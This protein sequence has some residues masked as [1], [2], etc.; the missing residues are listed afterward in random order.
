MKQDTRPDAKKDAFQSAL[1][2]ALETNSNDD[3][4]VS[5]EILALSKLFR[6]DPTVLRRY[7]AASPAWRVFQEDGNVFATRRWMID[8]EWRYT[9]HGYY[10]RHDI[11]PWSVSVIPDFQSRFTIGLSGKPWAPIR[12]NTTRLRAGKTVRANLSMG[13]QMQESR[14]VISADSMV[15]EVFEQSGA[16]DRRLTKAGLKFLEAELAP[17]AENPTWETSRRILPSDSIRTG[18]PS[19]EITG[20]GGTYHSAIWLNPGEL[21]MIYLKAFEVTK[22]TPLSANQLKDRSNEWIGWSDDPEEL[23]LS[24]T[25]FMI[26]EGD[27]GKPYAA[28]LEVWFVPDSGA[29]ERKLME[30]NFK[31][32]GWET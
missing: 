19:F 27:Y 29:P 28:R 30:R 22:G 6:D 9:L 4:T 20:I 23:F 16:P 12:R 3:P 24:N 8:S 10:T 21:G 18:I 31:I 13:N 14:C 25:E 7:L 15:V 2:A 17:L 32:E 1:L 5:G 11:D 26:Y